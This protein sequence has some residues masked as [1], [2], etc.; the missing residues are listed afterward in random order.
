M[1]GSCTSWS[2]F[3]DWPH[4]LGD[5]SLLQQALQLSLGTA[6]FTWRVAQTEGV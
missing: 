2:Q 3:P 6:V 5:D 4:P 1:G